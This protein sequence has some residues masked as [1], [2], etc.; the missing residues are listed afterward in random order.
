MIENIGG[1]DN[2]QNDGDG[3]GQYDAKNGDKD[4]GQFEEEEN[5]NGEEVTLSRPNQDSDD[6]NS[7][8][9]MKNLNI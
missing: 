8:D 1:D 9:V 7:D 2:G 6:L 5:D 4:D 3:N